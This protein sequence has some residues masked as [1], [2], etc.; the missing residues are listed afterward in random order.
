MATP[1]LGSISEFDPEKEEWQ[2]YAKR[3]DHFFAANEIDDAGKKR[4]VFLSV[5]GPSTYKLLT[6]LIAPAEP[7]TKTYKD[8]VGELTKHH[9]P[10]PSEVVQRLQFYSRDRKPG[11][12]V[13]T[14]VAELRSIAIFCNFEGTLDKMLRDRLVGGIDNVQIRR[15]LRQEKDLDFAKALEIA[16]SLEAVEKNEKTLQHERD[17][18]AVL[19]L[20]KPKRQDA[21]QK[22]QP[23]SRCGKSNHT[24]ANCRF[25]TAK[26]HKCGRIGHIKIACRAKSNSTSQ[27]SVKLV[28]EEG[29]N[30]D[31]AG[32][33]DLFALDA[34][35]SRSQPF[36]VDLHM[37]SVP[38]SMEL[39][40][41]ASLSIMSAETFR[42]HWPKRTLQPTTRKLR[43]YTG[44]MLD[45]AGTVQVN[46]QHGANG[47][48]DLP[49]MI[50]EMDGPTLLGRNW[51]SSLKLDWSELHRLHD[52]ALEEVLRKHS[53]V[54]QEDLGTLK[55]TQVKIHVDPSVSPKF[56]S[57]RP[58]P[59]AMCPMVDEALDKLVEQNVIEPVQ[60]SDWAAPIVPVL[61]ADKKT[62]R[63]C[64]D[65]SVTVNKAVQLDRYPIPR[66]EDL[67]AKLQGGQSFTKLDLSQAY[68]QLE[69]DE[70]SKK[71]V[72]INTH[73]GLF[74]YNRLPFGISSAPGIFQ[75][76]MEQLLKDI[77]S[78]VVYLDD[79][80]IT[81][82]T[83]AEHLATLD[84]VLDQLEKHGLRVNKNKCTF[85]APSVTYLGHKIDKEGLHP[86]DDK[87]KAV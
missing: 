62:V 65:F 13:S 54:F 10:K 44:E 9:S 85:L 41:G 59:Y 74:R 55:D 4:S 2:Q 12:S 83:D 30:S 20:S 42:H 70:D 29:K 33:Y 60:F 84:R 73:R 22:S 40:T 1:L 87:V 48:V 16:Q 15:R 76:V 50:V 69:L 49:L 78:V 66:V 23:C 52:G 51:L 72:V 19:K 68:Q 80:L 34:V 25:K 14:Y 53:S 79:I 32:E 5:V 17:A 27:G 7:A 81:G 21:P 26:C 37:D 8:L 31:A 11:E 35:V 61:K 3:L 36:M 46:V 28:L 47:A 57:A 67:F 64:G 38:I 6:N 58:V 63:I 24:A 18:D 75:R 43:T 86:T 77:P 71:L 45:I 39:D 82:R 56:C